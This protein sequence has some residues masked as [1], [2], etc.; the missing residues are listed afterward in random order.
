MATSTAKGK[1]VLRTW[2]ARSVKGKLGELKEAIKKFDILGV[3]ETW[4]KNKDRLVIPGFDVVRGDLKEDKQGGGLAFIIDRGIK[5]T[6]RKD[7]KWKGTGREI[8]GISVDFNKST[9]DIILIYRR[10][11]GRWL[12]EDWTGLFKNKR[13]GV[14]TIF[15]GDFNARNKVWNCAVD[16]REGLLLE[17]VTRENDLFIVNTFTNSR[18]GTG[19]RP[20]SSIDLFIGSHYVTETATI[21]EENETMGSDHQVLTLVLGNE[22]LQRIREVKNSTRKFREDKINWDLFSI[23][24]EEEA[25]RLIERWG[26][27]EQKDMVVVVEDRCKDFTAAISNAI[28]KSGGAKEEEEDTSRRRKKRT[29]FDRTKQK[30]QLWWDE[31][32]NE[33]K[34]TRRKAVQAF[35]KRPNQDNWIKMRDVGKQMKKLIEEKKTC[36][37]DEFAASIDCHTSATEAW[38]KIKQIKNGIGRTGCRNINEIEMN[39]LEDQEIEKIL[40][41]NLNLGIGDR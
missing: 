29:K 37:W 5:Y 21:I 41:H 2:N 1:F 34:R 13:Q 40:S 33:A 19:G 14:E 15:M 10:P 24:T 36:A 23:A 8:L 17:E 3:T 9:W 20:P 22:E 16:S 31:E 18:I 35:V 12:K 30:K 6:I 7:L 38:Q 11:G 32:C 39:K 26:E 25:E 28:R 4:L 27:G